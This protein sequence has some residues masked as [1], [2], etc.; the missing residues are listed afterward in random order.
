M[1]VSRIATVVLGI[2][3]IYLGIVFEQQNVAFMVGLAFA[4][5]ASCNF[6]VLLMSMFWRGLTTRGA[7]FGGFLGLISA[8]ALMVVLTDGLGEALLHNPAGS[9]LPLRQSGAVLDADRLRRHLAVLDPRPERPAQAE[10]SA[11]PAAVRPLP[12][13]PRGHGCRGALTTSEASSQDRAPGPVP[14]AFLVSEVC[15]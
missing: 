4:I 8:V 1:R 7:F 12:D 13:R 9:A 5:A 11:F 3:A 15:T 10:E 14:G 2:V 6:P